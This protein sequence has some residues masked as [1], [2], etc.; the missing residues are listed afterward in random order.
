MIR[1][2]SPLPALAF[3]LFLLAAACM[4]KT[5]APGAGSG[6]YPG[7]TDRK[8]NSG[9]A[10]GLGKETSVNPAPVWPALALLKTGENPIWFEFGPD[11]PFF[12]ESPAAASLSPYLPWPQARFS[13]DINVHNGFIIMAINRDGFLALGP[14]DEGKNAIL[15]HISAHGLWDLYT[16]ETFFYWKDKPAIL[17]YRNDFFYAPDVPALRPQVYILDEASTIP[18]G[19]FVP[20]LEMYP[21][22]SLWEAE[23]LH[24]GS[25]GLWYFRFKEKGIE[26]GNTFYYRTG[27]LGASAERISFSEWRKSDQSET[28]ENTPPLFLYLF[29]EAKEWFG[30]AKNPVVRTIS[31]DFEGPKFFQQVDDTKNA[32]DDDYSGFLYGYS[33]KNLA[34]LMYP[35]GHGLYSYGM[36]KEIFPFI[37]PSLP[38]GFVYTGIGILGDIFAASWEEQQEASIGAA[39]FM[40]MDLP[41]KK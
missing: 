9:A 25:D 21:N 29:T 17:L 34:L 18:L 36:G 7:T 26:Q 13:T 4:G 30:A 14:F 2:S 39:G 35:D 1:R 8:P 15:Y 31:P 16:A 38:D 23:T 10:Q 5:N 27:D 19:A 22:D 28:P 3:S 24:R 33:S 12:I 32:S 37:L 20:V 40:V 11:A 41:V 6:V